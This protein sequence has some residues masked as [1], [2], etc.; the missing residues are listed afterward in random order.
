M[1]SIILLCNSGLWFVV[2][3]TVGCGISFCHVTIGV[4]PIILHVIVGV[5]PIFCNMTVG[6]GL[7]FCHMAVGCGLSFCHMAWGV[8]YHFVIWLWGVVYHFVM[9]H[10]YCCGW[11]I[12][13]ECICGQSFCY[14]TVGD[15]AYHFVMWLWGCGFLIPIWLCWFGLPSWHVTIRYGLSFCH[16]TMEPWPNILSYDT[17]GSQVNHMKGTHVGVHSQLLINGDIF[18]H[19]TTLKITTTMRTVFGI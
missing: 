2:L 12:W 17:F 8:V 10:F 4:W 1:W 11:I 13:R 5:W 6:L 14:M 3:L 7:S 16:V 18:H 9:W 19:T 15:V